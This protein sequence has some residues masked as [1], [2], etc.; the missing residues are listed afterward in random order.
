MRL[1]FVT[2]AACLLTSILVAT[3]QV[4]AAQSTDMGSEKP[5]SSNA[6]LE[7]IVVTARKREEKLLDVPMSITAISG[8]DLVAAVKDFVDASIGAE[9]DGWNLNLFGRNLL[10]VAGPL[11]ATSTQWACQARPRTFGISIRKTF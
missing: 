3:A 8:E 5:D 6:M 11:F 7:D 4:T 2:A 9:W 10:N 1:S